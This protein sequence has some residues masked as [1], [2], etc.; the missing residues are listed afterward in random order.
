MSSVWDQVKPMLE[1]ALKHGPGEYEIDD[2]EAAI[3]ARDMQ[4]WVYGLGSRI[5][6]AAVTEVRVYPRTKQCVVIL[7][8][9]KSR[10]AW[11]E[12]A[13]AIEAWAA[14]NGCSSIMA[15]G[16]RGWARAVGWNELAT[17]TGK[18]LT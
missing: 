2:I 15:I 13:S 4:L 6:A 1:R 11:R 7:C 16:R 18:A 14:R 3:S 12:A 8:G 10:A 17:V 9:G 5:Q